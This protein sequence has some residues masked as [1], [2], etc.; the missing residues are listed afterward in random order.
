MTDML[1]KPRH[2][3]MT[4]VLHLIEEESYEGGA[5]V[6]VSDLITLTERSESTVRKAVKELLDGGFIATV[7]GYKP[8]AYV[9]VRKHDTDEPREVKNMTDEEPIKADGRGR[10]RDPGVEERDEKVL[11]LIGSTPEG[12]TVAELAAQLDVKP[13]IAYLSIWRLRKQGKVVKT[14]SGTR[15]PRWAKAA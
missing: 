9:A 2:T 11:S 12:L 5:L 7:E 8:T 15:A 3:L 10:P 6:H 1:I 14:P 13:G 4:E